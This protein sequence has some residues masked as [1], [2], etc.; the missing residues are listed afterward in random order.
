VNVVNDLTTLTSPVTG[1][2]NLAIAMSAPS[3]T[4]YTD[5]V[6]TLTISN[7]GSSASTGAIAVIDTLPDGLTFLSGSGAGWSF[8]SSGQVVFATYTDS[9]IGGG[10][11]T[12]TIT[13]DIGKAAKNITN[14]AW[15]S[16]GND[17][18]ASNNSASVASAVAQR[19]DISLSF[20]NP[21]TF[22]YGVNSTYS[23]RI[24]NG[25]SVATSGT[26]VVTD[27][28]PVGISYVSSTGSG[29]TVTYNAATRE[30]VASTSASLNGNSTQ[31]VTLNVAVGLAAYP[32]VTNTAYVEGG[33]QPPGEKDGISITTTV[34]AADLSLT[35][36]SPATF[37]Q[38]I[39]ADYTF[40][41]TNIGN[42]ATLGTI[43]VLDT[44]PVGMNY[45]SATGTGWTF[46]VSGRVV[47]ASFAGVISVSGATSFTITVKPQGAAVPSVTNRAYLSGGSQVNAGNDVSTVTTSVVAGLIDLTLSKTSP[48]FTQYVSSS[49]TISVWNTG[50]APSIG[51][52]IITDTLPAGIGFLSGTGAGWSFSATGSVVT[53]THADS[54]APGDTVPFTMNV[55]VGAAAASIT[56]RAYLSG[57]SDVTPANNLATMTTA[58]TLKPDIAV[59]LTSSTPFTYGNNE[60]YTIS[61]TNVGSATTSGTLTVID[62]LPV[63]ISY[64]SNSGSFW[65][66]AYN[67][68]TR[69]VTATSTR[70]V[71]AG[72]THQALGLTVAVG[73]AAYPVVTNRAWFSGG[74]ETNTANNGAITSSDVLAADLIIDQSAPTTFVQGVND[75][76]TITV[77][78]AGSAATS[79]TITV[80]DTLPSG[81][82][83]VSAV[84]TGWT[85]TGTG[86][87]VVATR[88]TAIASAGTAPFTV[89]VT[90]QAGAVPSV[91]NRAYV[92][93]G[94]DVDASNNLASLVTPAT[95]GVIDVAI[96]GSSPAFTQFAGST[97]S[98][99]LTN[100]GNTATSSAMTVLDTLPANVTFVSGS[101]AGWTFN[102]TGQVVT[103]TFAGTLAASGVTSFSLSVDVGAAASSITNLAYLSG[104]GDAT[105]GN[106]LATTTTAVTQRADLSVA[107][108]SSSPFTVG[109]TSETYSFVVT[110][111]G[112]A[113]STGTI[114]L[115]DTLPAG[116]AYL[117][118]SGNAWTVSYNAGTRV[119]T[120]TNNNGVNAGGNAQTLTLTVSVAAAAFP[121]S[122]N[123]VYL[124]GGGDA[125]AANNSG[126]TVS[127]VAAP[128]LAIVKTS[129]AAF[130]QG[131]NGNYTIT[132]SN[133]GTAT[134]SG[135]I[136]VRDSLPTGMNFVSASGT[137]WSISGT[138]NVVVATSTTVIAGGGSSVIIVTVAPQAS[139][140]PSVTNK[141]VVSGGNQFNLANDTSILT[142]P[143]TA[144]TVDLALSK[145]S[146]VFLQYTSN[147]YTMTVS[148]NGTIASSGTLT[149]V[150]TL[151]AGVSYASGTGS[152]WSFSANGQVVTATFAGALAAG[153]TSVITLNVDI[154]SAAASITNRA[155]LSGGA[156]A[157]SGNNTGTVTT[158]VTQRADLTLTQTSSAPF[159]YGGASETYTLAVQNIGSAASSGTFTITDTLPVGITYVSRT[160][161]A[162]TVTWNATNRE[163]TATNSAGIS[164]GGTSQS[165]VLTVTV[166][167]NAFPSVTNTAW[168]SGGADGNAANNSVSTTSALIAPD[169]AVAQSSPANFTQGASGTYTITVT[170]VGAGATNG[171]ITVRDTLPTGMTY[172]SA[173]GTNWT[174]TG[175]NNVVVATRTTSIAA[176]GNAAFTVTAVPGAAAVP[177]VTNKAVVSGGNQLNQANDTSVLSTPVSGTTVFVDLTVGVAASPNF[178]QQFN[179][180]YTITVSNIGTANSSGTVAVT[181]TL[182]A[183]V[184]FVSGAGAGWTFS[185]SGQVVSATSTTSIAL[186]GSAPFTITV[187]VT[188][189]APAS[190]TNRAWVSGGGEIVFNNDVSTDVVSGVVG[191]PALSLLHA[192]TPSG[193]VTPGTI[194]VASTQFL[195][196]GN[197]SAVSVVVVSGVPGFT[198]Y[199]L[200]S[201]TSSMPAG[202][203]ANVQ[204]TSDGTTWTYTP[205]SGGCGAPA[206]FD[207]C[208]TQVRWL[209]QAPLTAGS[210]GNTYLSSRVR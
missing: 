203:T 78:N 90:P 80:R 56:N 168:I 4:Q 42:A 7:I 119:V 89:T 14:T 30:V 155:Y 59:A 141:A 33:G 76:Y 185:T 117:S 137:N 79:G 123:T 173:T 182:P 55:D 52:T 93:G 160:G 200:N 83:Y 129:P 151:P 87:V 17:A 36:T 172:N 180:T 124:S 199:Q 66:V 187:L 191:T 193:T 67:A 148:N 102:A 189:S 106:N 77:T 170:N 122:T 1:T 99:T 169:L 73:A 150:D 24:R 15:V 178:Q 163:L 121:S 26:I 198:D 157:T 159:L 27:T 84:G 111:Y 21:V 34:L 136:T 53:A 82:T 23:I 176:G 28:L 107:V 115:V 31:T 174:I 96:A 139:A 179:S 108:S 114:T 38:S 144:G 127:T 149:V 164:A 61:L 142:T 60:T 175:V 126:A 138:G 166:D 197:A 143:V 46:G 146:S 10:S 147:S 167:A 188:P 104:G 75:S 205:V 64:V 103:A 68:A 201:V 20:T 44:L 134:T 97:Y 158:T 177:S 192:I 54:I 202:V 105:T 49:Y 6:Y 91:T 186:S 9:I 72:N 50:T 86:N 8:S 153:A 92:S 65:T 206:G 12:L 190:V 140:V 32:G 181:D 18:N 183:G 113:A 128:D 101:G 209:L 194:L 161:T 48:S 16:G 109:S 196:S 165:L 88:T 120:A 63:G 58:V 45:V 171:T 118:R 94:N 74:G 110:N 85:I 69:V 154:G 19:P 204:Y 2:T 39:N 116:V 184:T 35:K 112:G 156:D 132:V 100:S 125:F 130:A 95:S 195:N 11:T 43:T 25:G 162:W 131:L 3:L 135:T 51:A 29:W 152:G 5:G 37:G 22:T 98:F 81:M 207:R 47:T 133:V 40:N 70:T 210:S 57:G 208:V 13:A 71:T 145:T 62:T 41:V